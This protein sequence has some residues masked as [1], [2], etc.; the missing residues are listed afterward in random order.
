M[1]GNPHYFESE[2]LKAASDK[3]LTRVI[4]KYLTPFQLEDC[5]FNKD[6]TKIEQMSTEFIDKNHLEQCYYQKSLK[7]SDYMGNCALD[8]NIDNDTAG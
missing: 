8:C 6:P 1:G 2:Q 4:R 3:T 7:W 5:Y